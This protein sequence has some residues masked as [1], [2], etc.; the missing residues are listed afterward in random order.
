MTRLQVKL[1]GMALKE[2]LPGYRPGLMRGRSLPTG[3]STQRRLAD[4]NIQEMVRTI[5]VR[6]QKMRLNVLRAALLIAACG[7]TAPA[8]AQVAATQAD[9]QRYAA[10]K[11]YFDR[12]GDPAQVIQLT[13]E[14][15][16]RGI[17][18]S[19]DYIGPLEAEAARLAQQKR[20]ATVPS[21]NMPP[22]S[23]ADGP[24]VQPAYLP[25]PSR[26]SLTR[27]QVERYNAA[28]SQVAAGNPQAALPAFAALC[29]EGMAEACEAERKV[30]DFQTNS[31]RINRYNA[32]RKLVSAGN[33][34]AA[35]S[36]F[37]A[38]CREGMAEGC[39]VERNISDAIRKAQTSSGNSLQ[40]Q[41][42]YTA[43][44]N[45]PPASQGFTTPP[46]L[47]GPVVPGTSMARAVPVT[48]NRE[49]RTEITSDV[50]DC[51]SVDK[52]NRTFGSFINRC[53]YRVAYVFCV[54]DAPAEAWSSAHPCVAGQS[55]KTLGFVGARGADAAHN[56]GGKT[57][58]WLACRHTLSSKDIVSYDIDIRSVKFN[59]GVG[60]TGRCLKTISPAG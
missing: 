29:R 12:T 53:D 46:G 11:A 49:P 5:M 10:A 48:N 4:T 42:G 44:T 13:K 40:N 36:E 27:A 31:A 30:R 20:A 24:G 55:P 6:T 7:L 38:L 56:R 52:Q 57:T 51:L 26:P 50:S 16:R 28:R 23:P 60:I 15:C 32:A 25:P 43:G 41:T 14:F 39:A 45:P 47:A 3:R 34:Q 58:Y 18:N 22:R 8:F 35:R 2:A 21:S 9:V 17:V 54:L 59:A 19:C 1:M 33:Y 37:G